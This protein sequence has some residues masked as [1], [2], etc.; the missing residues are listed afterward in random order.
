MANTIISINH[1]S[2]FN[3]GIDGT[4]RRR[5]EAV[6]LVIG[7]IRG[8]VSGTLKGSAMTINAGTATTALAS[9][10]G[11]VTLASGASGTY[12]ATINGV[13][14]TVTFAT[15]LSNTA[16]LLAAAINSSTNALV[17]YHVRAAAT[18]AV[19]ALVAQQPGITGNTITL[20]ASAS[21]GTATAS[22]ARLTGGTG[23]SNVPVVVTL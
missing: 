22:G 8:L 4:S 7:F 20:A 2:P 3:L 13:A 15:S 16:T 9:A 21:V 12:T 23:G 5:N 14:V 17:Q 6:N 10:A 1:T 18:G 19:V 11:T